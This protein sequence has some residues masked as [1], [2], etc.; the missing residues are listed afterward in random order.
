MSI[1]ACWLAFSLLAAVAWCA[2][3][4]SCRRSS[5][6]HPP[7]ARKPKAPRYIREASPHRLGHEVLWVDGRTPDEVWAA[8][9]R[10]A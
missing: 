4:E 7:L 10:V 5:R 8:L 9:E 6:R 2:T 1:L 3:V